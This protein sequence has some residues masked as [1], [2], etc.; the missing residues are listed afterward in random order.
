MRWVFVLV[1]S[2]WAGSAGADA[3]AS[4][5]SS[6]DDAAELY[7]QYCS[8]CHGD[9][10]DGRSRAGNSF[11]PPPRDFTGNAV[12]D[13]TRQR[14]IESVRDG[15]PGTAM[16]PWGSQLSAT[17]IESV[18]DYIRARFM[19]ASSVDAMGARIYARTCSVCHGDRGRGAVWASTSL[20][21][22]P[23]D[24][25]TDQSALELTR[26]R[27]IRAASF[28]R[29]DTAMPGFATQ[30]S[31]TQIEA[32]VDY[33]RVRFM[34]HEATQPATAKVESGHAHHNHSGVHDDTAS[35]FP[36][37]LVGNERRGNAL[38]RQNCVP[39]HGRQGNGQGPRA[40]FI[41][42]KPRDFT[43]PAA[44]DSLSRSHLFAAIA[45]GT[46]GTEMPAWEKVLDQQSIADVAE[47]VYRAF[48]RVDLQQ[49]APSQ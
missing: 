34:R 1:M 17:Q 40:Y 42:P 7:R 22:R 23:R 20:S 11:A 36:H 45:K 49:V 15:R 5:H 39:C 9:K 8:V 21:S 31:R 3:S 24:F 41:L 33:I 47:Y 30:L 27:M 25:T 35:A 10:G 28:G 44:R 37:D 14:M 2:T 29:A 38:Y 46:V 12:G 43:H 4:S 26:E 48:I 13:L 6:Q 16:A 18:V 32:V 19:S